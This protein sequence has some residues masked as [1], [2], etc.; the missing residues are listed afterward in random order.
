M[1]ASAATARYPLL[2]DSRQQQDDPAGRFLIAQ[3]PDGD[4]DVLRDAE[5]QYRIEPRER[6]LDDFVPTCWW[7]Q[8]SPQSH[9]TQGLICSLL[10]D[11]GRISISGR[12]LITT[13]GGPEPRSSWPPTTRC[14]P[15]TASI[16]GSSST[17]Y[18]R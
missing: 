16:S 10:T 11:G 8:T 7:Q 3:T 18:L 14:W 6:V 1:S 9:F 17:G 12:T 4:L 2:L 13:S 5:P 15:P